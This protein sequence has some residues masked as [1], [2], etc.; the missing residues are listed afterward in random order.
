MLGKQQL[1]A[2]DSETRYVRI[3][4]VFVIGE[5]NDLEAK[6]DGAILAKQLHNRQELEFHL[7]IVDLE[8]VECA[9]VTGEDLVI[10]ITMPPSFLP[11]LSA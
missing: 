2:L 4:E 6:Q 7:C 5:H 11:L 1:S 10:F 9:S 8:L 3:D